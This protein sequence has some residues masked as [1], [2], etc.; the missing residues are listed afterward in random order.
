MGVKNTHYG[1]FRLVGSGAQ[2]VVAGRV[3]R[4][5]LIMANEDIVATLIRTV[6]GQI[7]GQA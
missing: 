6:L 7:S 2:T 4:D 5:E 1:V 3:S